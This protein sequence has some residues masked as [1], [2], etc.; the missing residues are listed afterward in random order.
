MTYP[1]AEVA[2]AILDHAIPVQID[3]SKTESQQFLHSIHHIWTPDVRVFGGDGYELYRFDGFLPP[4]EFIA[5]TLCGFAMAYLR[6][7]RF[8]RA[9]AL[10]VDVLKRF[11]TTYAA[12]EAQY[13][14]GVSRYRRDPGSDELLTQWANLRSRYPGSEYRVKQSFKEFP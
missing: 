5:R 6:L 1:H 3:N 7:K 10:Y 2:Q 11:S 9:E 4:P 14:L 12:P 13:Y 8:D